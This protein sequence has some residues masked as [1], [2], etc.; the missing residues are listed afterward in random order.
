MDFTAP[1]E[2]HSSDTS[3]TSSSYIPSSSRSS[4]VTILDNRITTPGGISARQLLITTAGAAGD[5]PAVGGAVTATGAMPVGCSSNAAVLAGMRC[6]ASLC[7]AT[8]SLFMPAT[9]PS[10]SAA[11]SNSSTALCVAPPAALITLKALS[12]PKGVKSSF[13][14]SSVTSEGKF[15][16]MMASIR[17]APPTPPPVNPASPIPAA[18]AEGIPPKFVIG[19][20]PG[21]VVV[22]DMTVAA[23]P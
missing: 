22:T 5:I 19:G 21:I 8:S 2:L 10:T 11:S 14:W 20:W 1:W 18:P 6:T 7:P 17:A 4:A 9:T 16:T 13:I 23:A 3:S 12:A 15:V